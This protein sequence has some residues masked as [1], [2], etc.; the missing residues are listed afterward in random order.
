MATYQVTSPDGQKYRITA[1]DG[2]GE[3]EVMAYAQRSF[4]M[5]A[6]PQPAPTEA[7]PADYRSAQLD[8]LKNGLGGLVRGAGSI[9]A[10]LLWPVDKITDMVQGDRGPGLTG[11]VTGQRPISRNEER[12]QKMDAALQ[13]LGSDPESLAYKTG[14]LGGEIAGTAGMGGLIANT[15]ARIPMLAKNAAPLLDAIRTGGM[16]AQ[17]MGGLSGLGV[18]ATGGAIT[19][20]ASAGAV[21]PE[22][23]GIGAMIGGGFP[24]VTKAAGAA[25]GAIGRALRGGGVTP[26]VQALAERA[27]QLGIDIPADRLTNSK[28]L[29]AL[30]ASL[31]YVPLSGRAGSEAAMG[32]QLDTA[33][34]KTFGQNSSNV[35]MALRKA[36]DALGGQFEKTLSQNSVKFDKQLMD[37][38]AEVFNKAESEL[39]SEALKPISAKINQLLEK[40]ADGVIDGKAAYVIKRDLDRIGRSNAPNAWH[41]LE[42]KQKLMEA[43]DRSLGPAEAAAFAQTRQ[44]YSNMLALQKLATNGAEGGLSAARL[45]NMK[46]INNEPLQELADIA[47]QFV[48]P[49]EGAH[50]AA[51]R[52][53][54]GTGAGLAGMFSPTV[55]PLMLGG[56]ATGRAANSMLNSGAMKRFVLNQSQPGLLSGADSLLP[57]MYQTNPVI[58]RGLLSGQ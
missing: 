23:A 58:G 54:L 56:M 53:T 55:A 34:S 12:R 40:G 8:G 44:Q 37:D 20:A 18:R 17:G 28:P 25:G 29:N 21:K 43:L 47:A 24:V 46:N 33:V 14:K 19:G 26:E 3:E 4:K 10:T 42:L 39:G 31:N 7:T 48:K 9:G 45:G 22:D 51:Q 13:Q 36:E 16:S 32:R 50:G 41:A 5:A 27:Q 11:L 38:V 57:L 15:G 30:A 2:A 6:T 52:V 35:T 49:R 1:P